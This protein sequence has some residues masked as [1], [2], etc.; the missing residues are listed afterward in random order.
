MSVKTTDGF[1][2]LANEFMLYNTRIA[3]EVDLHFGIEEQNLQR[4]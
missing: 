3:K 2:V 4:F 1:Y